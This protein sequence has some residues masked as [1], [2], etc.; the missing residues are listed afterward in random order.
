MR[1]RCGFGLLN[2]TGRAGIYPRLHDSV[3]FFR[4]F[5]D[6]MRERSR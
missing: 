2:G 1:P 3:E 6:I 4:R 5:V